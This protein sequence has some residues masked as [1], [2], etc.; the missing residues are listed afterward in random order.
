MTVEDYIK[1]LSLSFQQL[2][3][4]VR[5]DY[6]KKYVRGQFDFFGITAVP[7]R[8][9]VK[10]FID[11]SG[12]PEPKNI[13]PLLS[14]FWSLPEREYQHAGIEIL[15]KKPMLIG[16]DDI[17]CIEMMITSKSWWDTVDGIAIFIC[18]NYFRRFHEQIVPVTGRWIDS[19]NIWLMRSA[20]LFQLKY[21]ADTD[22]ELLTSYINKVSSH[23][24]F[25]IRKAIGWVL[26]DYSKRNPGWVRSFVKTYSLSGLSFREATKYI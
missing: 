25:F 16:R 17:G 26:R 18:G 12:F 7:F 3:D 24:D 19:E 8:K 6:S 15:R 4:P 21:K 9:A 13:L 2:A 1:P 20:L 11:H 10:E 14:L 22:T 5:A 23:K